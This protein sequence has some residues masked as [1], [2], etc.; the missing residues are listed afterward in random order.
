[1]LGRSWLNIA[2]PIADP[3]FWPCVFQTRHTRRLCLRVRPIFRHRCDSFVCLWTIIVWVQIQRSYEANPRESMTYKSIRPSTGYPLLKLRASL[4]WWVQF[5]PQFSGWSTTAVLPPLRTVRLILKI[6]I[7]FKGILLWFWTLDE[8]TN[9]Q[10]H[11]G[12][13]FRSKQVPE[14]LLRRSPL[15][16]YN[17]VYQNEIRNN[18]RDEVEDKNEQS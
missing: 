7:S 17:P 3:E 5:Y 9:L 1:M 6:K 14:S 4:A 10:T 8:Q 11:S 12:F 18:S 13:V 2:S 15:L 16:S